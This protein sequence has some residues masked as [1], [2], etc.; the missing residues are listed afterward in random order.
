MYEELVRQLREYAKEHCPLDRGS[1][2]CGCIDARNAADA[3]EELTAIAESY[4]RSM[5]AWADEAANAQPRWM[6]VT[7]E[8]PLKVGDDGYNGYLV[9]DNGYYALADYATDKQDNVPYFHVDGEWDTDV[10]HWM[11]LPQAPE[12]PKEE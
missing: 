5:E 7:E 4:K 1:G 2:I 10:T 6:S 3:I 9:Y 8:P 11:P 12:P